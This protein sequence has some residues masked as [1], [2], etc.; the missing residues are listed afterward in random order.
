M[1][2]SK[3]SS[4]R[5]PQKSTRR[6]AGPQ[7]ALDALLADAA[8]DPLRRALWLDALDQRLRPCLPPALAAH[9]RLANLDGGR[10]VFLV[11]SPVWR[12]KLRL[13]A[14]EVLDAARSLG[15]GVTELVVKV[16]T[17]PVHPPERADT[18]VKPMSA[19]ARDAL[20]AALASLKNP[21][22]T[23]PEDDS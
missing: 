23:G 4:S 14:P 12:A 21:A 16:T 8:F 2:D 22:S 19:A 15:L 10:L 5:P 3:S 7:D 18:K 11:D 9:A 17:S 20:Q 1:S 13:A 6:T